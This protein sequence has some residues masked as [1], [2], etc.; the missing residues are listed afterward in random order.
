MG[1][2]PKLLNY[3]VYCTI[4]TIL[5]G[6]PLQVLIDGFP[7]VFIPPGPDFM[8]EPGLAPE[9]DIADLDLPDC[10]NLDNLPDGI[11]AVDIDGIP[12]D[13]LRSV[14]G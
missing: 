8:G 9:Y 14:H 4:E 5:L 1:S 7:E 11:T 12:E 3:P 2:G 13:L 6:H 10:I